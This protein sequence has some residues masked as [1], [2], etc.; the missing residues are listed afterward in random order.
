M[1]RTQ[2][3]LKNPS[4]R[5][6]DIALPTVRG[7]PERRLLRSGRRSPLIVLVHGLGCAGCRSYLD[8]LARSVDSITEWDGEVMLVTP[9]SAPDEDRELAGWPRSFTVLR[10]EER[11]LAQRLKVEAPAVAVADRWGEIRLLE[12]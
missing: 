6:P 12:P 2:N 9:D 10:D 8:R 4:A 11:R 1:T 7:G 5:L 3:D